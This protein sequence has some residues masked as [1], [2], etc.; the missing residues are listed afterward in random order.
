MTDNLLFNGDSLEVLCGRIAAPPAQSE[1][2]LEA[3]RRSDQELQLQ[4]WTE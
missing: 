4:G 1:H 3:S 2:W